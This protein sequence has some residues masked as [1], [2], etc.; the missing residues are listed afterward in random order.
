MGSDESGE[1]KIVD[2]VYRAEMGGD[3]RWLRPLRGDKGP[4]PVFTREFVLWCESPFR[5]PLTDEIDLFLR[6]WCIPVGHLGNLVVGASKDLNEG[7]FCG[8]PRV[9]HGTATA[10]LNGIGPRIE[11]EFRFGMFAGMTAVAVGLEDW[12][13]LVEVI[14]GSSRTRWQDEGSDESEKDSGKPTR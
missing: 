6:E 7:A 8:T 9:D 10:S 4:V 13:D 2:G 11:A 5:D 12:L 3:R 1:D 14:R